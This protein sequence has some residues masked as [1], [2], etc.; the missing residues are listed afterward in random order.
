MRADMC[1]CNDAGAIPVAT[2]VGGHRVHPDVLCSKFIGKCQRHPDDSVLGGGARH[3]GPLMPADALMFTRL[4]PPCSSRCGIAAAQVFQAPMRLTCVHVRLVRMLMRIGPGRSSDRSRAATV[5]RLSDDQV[6]AHCV[7]A[8]VDRPRARVF[9]MPVT[10][11]AVH[12]SAQLDAF[13]ALLAA[14]PSEE[15]LRALEGVTDTRPALRALP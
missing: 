15:T 7:H 3:A 4:P 9:G 5:A 2:P 10:S 11:Y 8:C 14:T 6:A 12:V 1:S 13:V